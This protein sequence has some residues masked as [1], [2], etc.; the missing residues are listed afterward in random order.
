[1]NTAAPQVSQTP[2]LFDAHLDLAMSRGFS[3]KPR[4]TYGPA[5]SLGV[6][7]FAEVCDVDLEHGDAPALTAEE[8]VARLGA[9]CPEGLAIVDGAVLPPVQPGLGK[10]VTAADYVVAPAP[11]GLR[12]DEARL[13][14]IAAAFLAREQAIVA[15]GDKAIDVRALV[16]EVD[17]I[18]GPA[19]ARLT[20]ALGW[21]TGPLLR[22]RVGISA[23]GSATP[24]EVA[25]ALDIYG[26]D[27]PRARH[28]LVARLALI[29]LEAP[30][31]VVAPPLELPGLIHQPLP[32]VGARVSDGGPAGA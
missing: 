25:K 7:S 5:L 11:D 9:V 23:A 16:G 13:G 20:A 30:V 1:M 12:F 6:P 4:I 10:L 2:L 32:D 17:V 18:A 24:I 26:P 28:A 19:A 21:E 3:P 31:A 27:D 15:R 29:G 22:A 8:V 14:R